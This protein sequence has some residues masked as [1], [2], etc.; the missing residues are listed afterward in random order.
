MEP[1]SL[2]TNSVQAMNETKGLED[3]GKRHN[4]WKDLGLLP[5][6]PLHTNPSDSDPV[7]L[8]I[9]LNGK[10]EG[11]HVG[12]EGPVGWTCE[13]SRGNRADLNPVPETIK[14]SKEVE[15]GLSKEGC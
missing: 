6:R 8:T 2:V 15:R 12:P 10:V 3:L 7:L 11:L 4:P 9:L 1:E 13:A 5:G 14:M